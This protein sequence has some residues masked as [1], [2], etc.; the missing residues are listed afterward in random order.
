[1][2]ARDKENVII[3]L[4]DMVEYPDTQRDMFDDQP[5]TVG[6]VISMPSEDKVCIQPEGGG[7]SFILDA[8]VCLIKSSLVQDIISLSTDEELRRIIEGAETRF[9][10]AQVK[11]TRSPRAK[12]K[13]KAKA[14]PFAIGGAQ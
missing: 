8:S 9:S 6:Q 3:S 5:V 10:L 13:V 14:N 11:P 12:K 2:K 7:L 1:M 4:R